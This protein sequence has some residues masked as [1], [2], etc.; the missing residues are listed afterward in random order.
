MNRLARHGLTACAMICLATGTAFAEEAAGSADAGTGVE[1][2]ASTDSDHTSVVKLLGRGL[3][4]DEGPDE[5]AGLAIE[6]AWFTPNGGKTRTDNRV[7]I[8]LANKAGEN[9]LWRAR[10]GTDGHTW[11]GAANV[12]T[13]DRSKEVFLEREI[14]ETRRGVDQGIYYTFGGASFDFPVSDRDTLNAMAGM[15]TFTGDNERLHLRASYV[16]VA[17]P[18]IGLSVQLKGR[19]F[20][21]THPGEFDYYSPKDFLQLLPVVQMRRFDSHGWMYL[22]AAGLGAQHATGNHWQTA[23]FAQLRV[24]SPRGKRDLSL[25]ALAEY[26]NA[27]LTGAGDYHYVMGRFGLTARF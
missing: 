22:A 27:S 12:R 5:Y 20:H 10:L 16:H 17:A 6:R 26:S 9:W 11:V 21:S 2:F 7:Y 25:F 15:Q 13:K 19:Y 1:L 24:E 23:R 14:V 3:F 8:D 4:K 18:K